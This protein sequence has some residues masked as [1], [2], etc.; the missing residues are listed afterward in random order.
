MYPYYG[1]ALYRIDN[2]VVYSIRIGHVG[3]YNI[4]NYIVIII[5]IVLYEM[6]N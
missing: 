3:I 1:A 2:Y 4:D 5:A 6:V